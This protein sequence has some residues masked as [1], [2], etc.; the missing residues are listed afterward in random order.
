MNGSPLGILLTLLGATAMGAGNPSLKPGHN[1]VVFD[2]PAPLGTDAELKRRFHAA[3]DAPAFD[4]AK[5]SFRVDVPE[6]RKQA[7]AWGLFVW[8]DASQTP[9]IP[10]DWGPILAEKKLLLVAP[11]N[12]GNDRGRVYVSGM[13]GGGR[14]ASMLGVAYADVFTGAFPMVGVNFYKPVSTGETTKYWLPLYQPPE[15]ILERSK[16]KNRFV[17]LTGETDFNRD[18]TQRV[19]RDG[20]KAEGFRS[21]LYLE[22]PGMGHARPPAA[23]LAKGVDFLD[24]TKQT[25]PPPSAG[26]ADGRRD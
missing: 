6:S 18:N 15:R 20:F 7:G 19:Y 23:W 2:Q 4:L 3:K 11:N 8:V 9:N 10:A 21:V 26:R 14:V 17:L 24:G 16:A 5:E 13:S 22:V 1:E 25:G 12:A